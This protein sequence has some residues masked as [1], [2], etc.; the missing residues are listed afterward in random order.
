MRPFTYERPKAIAEAV[1]MARSE[2]AGHVNAPVQYLGGGTTLLDLMKLDVMQ[3]TRLV[4]ISR[5]DDRLLRGV[6]RNREGLRIG[7][8]SS[9]AELA[10]NGMLARDYP[11]LQQSLWLAASQQLRNMARVGGNV[12][13]RTRCPY[14]RDTS[15]SECNKRI[16]GSG[17]AAMDGVNRL[18]AVLGV[19][20]KCIAAYPGDWAQGLAALDAVVEVLGPGGARSVPFGELHRPPGETPHIETSLQPGELITGF[21]V[22]GE[23]WP[24]SLYRKVRDRESYAFANASAAVALRMRGD[25]AEDIRIGLGGVATTP[26][27]ARTA[28]GM[29]RGK[30]LTEAAIR[31]AAEAEFAQARPR[32]HNRFKVALGPATIT[33]ALLEAKAMEV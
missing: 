26:W 27:R 11:V 8:L 10:D 7:A 13:Q 12:L 2:G 19:S 6:S 21:V 14:F 5:L 33:R 16:P 9:M 3:P 17:C 23:P 30:P 28:E 20:D 18:H 15:Y 24:R 32:E 25:V 4:D 29:L 31:A 22:P 1:S